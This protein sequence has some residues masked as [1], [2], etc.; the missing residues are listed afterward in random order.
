M[1]AAPARLPG[2]PVKGN[3]WACSLLILVAQP[4]PVLGIVPVVAGL[5]GA[6]GNLGVARV[7]REPARFSATVR[8][9]YRK[10]QQ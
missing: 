7:L 4:V 3:R 6:L 10:V 8:G 9:D 5:P 2:R 1:T